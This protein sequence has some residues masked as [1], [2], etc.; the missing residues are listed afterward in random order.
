MFL[1]SHLISDFDHCLLGQTEMVF[2]FFLSFGAPLERCRL[3]VG[4]AKLT[5]MCA[6]SPQRAVQIFRNSLS[7]HYVLATLLMVQITIDNYREEENFHPM[8]LD[9]TVFLYCQYTKCIYI[10]KVYVVFCGSVAQG[11]TML[12]CLSIHQIQTEMS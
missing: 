1:E 9:R 6:Y 7:G 4:L 10:K 2:L 3:C 8:L 12:V 5:S 11:M